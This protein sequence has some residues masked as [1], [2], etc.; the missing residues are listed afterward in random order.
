MSSV[1]TYTLTVTDPHGAQAS[2]HFTLTVTSV[3]PNNQAPYFTSTP[4]LNAQVGQPW[5]YTA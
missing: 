1:G 4:P 5:Q 2:T 3:S